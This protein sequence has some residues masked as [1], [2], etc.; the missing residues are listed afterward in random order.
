VCGDQGKKG[1]EENNFQSR[2]FPGGDIKVKF[3]T[4]EVMGGAKGR[5]HEKRT[6]YT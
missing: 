6:A 4:P 2:E 1:G 5:T 3:A